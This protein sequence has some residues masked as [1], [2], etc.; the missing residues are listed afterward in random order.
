MPLHP[1][2][3]CVVLI[4]KHK[5]AWRIKFAVE[6]LM[7]FALSIKTR[8]ALYSATTQVTTSRVMTCASAGAGRKKYWRRSTGTRLPP[9]RNS[10]VN[11]GDGLELDRQV[12]VDLEADADLK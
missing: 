11:F 8:L 12:A 7:K 10:A 2:S 4:P 3:V 6:V 5:D 9:P 1:Y